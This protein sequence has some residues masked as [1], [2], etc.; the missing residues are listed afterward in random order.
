MSDPG[1]R[2]GE[3]GGVDLAEGTAGA[4]ACGREHSADKA[5]QSAGLTPC[6]A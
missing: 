4:E 1:S 3:A 5:G 2:Y 6:Q